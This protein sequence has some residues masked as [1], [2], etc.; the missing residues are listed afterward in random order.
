ML[1]ALRTYVVLGMK[2]HNYANNKVK[3]GEKDVKTRHYTESD[4][5]DPCIA[6]RNDSE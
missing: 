4:I 2:V 5:G 1:I 3:H 6:L